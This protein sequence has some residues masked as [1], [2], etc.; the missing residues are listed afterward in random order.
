MVI[1]DIQRER[2][3][4]NEL[5][6]KFSQPFPNDV[7]NKK[8]KTKSFQLFEEPKKSIQ[9]NKIYRGGLLS[10]YRHGIGGFK[11]KSNITDDGPEDQGFIFSSIGQHWLNM[12][13]G[14]HYS[15][16][17]QFMPEIQGYYAFD[18]LSGVGKI[19]LKSESTSFGHYLGECKND[20]VH[21][22]GVIKLNQDKINENT[23]KEVLGQENLDKVLAYFGMK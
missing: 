3:Q 19:E 22:I 2:V 1:E 8:L 12:K 11:V 5:D 15:Q 16:G 10:K 4:Q 9:G 18:K 21:G 14:Y 7:K 20:E 17:S 13:N 23:W 6:E